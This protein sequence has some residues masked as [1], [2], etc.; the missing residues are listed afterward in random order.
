M[1]T[2]TAVDRAVAAF[3][4]ALEEAAEF[5]EPG[6]VELRVEMEGRQWCYRLVCRDEGG[7]TVCHRESFPC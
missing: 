1:L 6:E 5:V 2:K 4:E 7:K 3:A